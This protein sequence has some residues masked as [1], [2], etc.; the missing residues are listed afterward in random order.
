MRILAHSIDSSAIAQINVKVPARDW[1]VHS[2]GERDYGIDLMIQVFKDK[3]PTGNCFFVQAKGTQTKFTNKVKMA[4]FPVD[5]I[6]YALLFNVP[7][8]VFYISTTSKVIK[9][10]WLQKY[11]ELELNENKPKWRDQKSVTLYFPDENDLD[12]NTAK[13]DN[14]L[15]EH[16][17]EIE[18][19]EF[20]KLYEEL[21]LHTGSVLTGQYGV[22]QYCEDICIGLIKIKWLINHLGINTESHGSNINIF[23]LKDAFY[24]IHTNNHISSDEC[25]VIDE[26][27]EILECIKTEIISKD[28]LNEMAYDYANIIPF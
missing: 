18:S 22:S 11:V 14:I 10:I 4:N 7:F 27:L 8:F 2:I 15:I 20:L 16:R 23:N 1:V 3:Q 19:L 17:V 26:Q 6:K 5:T 25:T 21:V 12:T 24:N 13:I 28:A 9:Y